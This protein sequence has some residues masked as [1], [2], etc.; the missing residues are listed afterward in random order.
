MR[1]AFALKPDAVYI[2]GDGAFTDDTVERLLALP[3]MSVTIHTMGFAMSPRAEYGFRLIAHKFHGSFTEVQI[4]PEMAELS[5]RTNRPLNQEFNG[6]WGV[7]LRR[8]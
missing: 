4:S 1:L 8:R 2:L 3:P 7:S 6:V 5:F